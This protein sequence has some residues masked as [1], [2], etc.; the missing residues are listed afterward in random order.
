MKFPCDMCG[1]TE[2]DEKAF[3]FIRDL[4]GMDKRMVLKDEYY[5]CPEC[6]KKILNLIHETRRNK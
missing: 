4:S 5:I 1:I 2:V 6:R 3:L